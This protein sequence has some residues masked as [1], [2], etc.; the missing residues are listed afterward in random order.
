MTQAIEAKFSVNQDSIT[1]FGN[2]DF[3]STLEFNQLLKANKIKNVVFSNCNGGSVIDGYKIALLIRKN[4]LN[5]EFNG[6]VA[7][8]CSIAF[9]GGKRRSLSNSMYSKNV[10]LFHP[11]TDPARA[12]VTEI[13]KQLLR[14]WKT[15]PEAIAEESRKKHFDRKKYS[16]ELNTRIFK[17]FEEQT[18]SGSNIIFK[19][20]LLNSEEKR[21]NLFFEIYVIAGFKIAERAYLCSKDI[22]TVNEYKDCPQPVN[23]NLDGLKILT[24]DSR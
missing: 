19:D 21:P 7:S 15:S 23:T 18:K 13:E 11:T 5:T 12:D 6:F 8:A 3:N 16:L 10:L 20:I 24:A 17:L 22:D 1:V 14:Q 9:L 2:L 4:N